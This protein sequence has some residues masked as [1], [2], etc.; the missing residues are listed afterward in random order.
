MN[1]SRFMSEPNPGG[2]ANLRRDFMRRDTPID[3][4]ERNLKVADFMVAMRN[5]TL[6]AHGCSYLAGWYNNPAT[7]NGKP[8][9]IGEKLML[10]VSEIGEAMEADRKSLADDHLP[11]RS[12]IEVELADAVIRIFDLA[13]CLDLDLGGAIIDKM[14]Y[15][16]RRADHKPEA[17]AAGGKKY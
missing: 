13:G 17:R 4:I 15:N 1:N 8:V 3:H 14:N 16:A 2:L 11:D 7:G 12:G 5:L 6:L 9:N 10:I